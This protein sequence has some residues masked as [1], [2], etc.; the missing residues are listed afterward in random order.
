MCHTR[1]G[2]TV[3]KTII[4]SGVDTIL[5]GAQIIGKRILLRLAQ[6]KKT[7]HIREQAVAHMKPKLNT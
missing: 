7:L 5:K 1:I 4:R 6:F 3:S 2:S